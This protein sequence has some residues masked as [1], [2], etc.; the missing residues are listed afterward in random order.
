MDFW[1]LHSE[2]KGPNNQNNKHPE[3]QKNK[4]A[5]AFSVNLCFFGFGSGVVPDSEIRAQT[6]YL[7]TNSPVGAVFKRG[8]SVM[9]GGDRIYMYTHT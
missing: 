9:R 4:T 8:W 1:F 7:S 6:R 2:T 5:P 3:K